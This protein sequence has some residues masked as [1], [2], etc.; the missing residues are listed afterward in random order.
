MMPEAGPLL[1]FGLA[2]LLG[3]VVRIVTDSFT[4][5][6]SGYLAAIIFGGPLPV[7]TGIIKPSIFAKLFGAGGSRAFGRDWFAAAFS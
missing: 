6:V 7:V 1:A 2:I 5:P 3:A 4:L